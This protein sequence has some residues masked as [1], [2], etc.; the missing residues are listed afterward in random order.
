[1]ITKYH[2]TSNA[3]SAVLQIS[4]RQSIFLPAVLAIHCSEWNSVELVKLSDSKQSIKDNIIMFTSGMPTRPI[5][6][7]KT[8]FESL[9]NES[10][11]NKVLV[12]LKLQRKNV[13]IYAIQKLTNLTLIALC[14]KEKKFSFENYNFTTD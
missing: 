7:L 11:D 3:S 14:S 12:H 6:V 13:H 4:S 8:C 5:E 9:L 1:M 10:H 2:T